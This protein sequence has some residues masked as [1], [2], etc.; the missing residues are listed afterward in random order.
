VD[1]RC[2]MLLFM[3]SRAQLVAQRIAPAIQAG[4]LVL[5]DRFISSTLAYQGTAGGL[6]IEDI[7]H[8]GRIAVR[9]YWPDLTVIF[10]VDEQTAAS[11]LSPL[12]DR[13]EQKGA[14]YHRTVRRGYLE[15]ARKDPGRYLVVDATVSADAVF[16]RLTDGL[17]SKLI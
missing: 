15:Q 16:T 11:R 14:E 2:E 1:I 13:I 6:P 5:A 10:D 3:A 7:L 17:R 12:L 8:V 4:K 9:E